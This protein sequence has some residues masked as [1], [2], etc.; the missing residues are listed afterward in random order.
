MDIPSGPAVNGKGVA[1]GVST[2]GHTSTGTAFIGWDPKFARSGIEQH[3][4]HL[5]SGIISSHADTDADFS[6]VSS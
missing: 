6:I 1:L 5:S 4:K 2:M 3:F